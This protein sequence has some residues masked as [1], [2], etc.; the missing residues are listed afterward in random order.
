MNSS[1]TIITNDGTVIMPADTLEKSN[2]LYNVFNTNV[3]LIDLTKSIKVEEAYDTN[4]EYDINCDDLEYIKEFYDEEL[5]HLD[6]ETPDI[7]YFLHQWKINFF[8]DIPHKKLLN[9]HLTTNFLEFNMD[10][11]LC[12][13]LLKKFIKKKPKHTSLH[14]AIK[15]LHHANVR[16]INKYYSKQRKFKTI[17]EFNTYFDIKDIKS[18][19]VTTSTIS[20]PKI[21]TTDK[22]KS[23]V[24][25][26]VTFYQAKTII[27]NTTPNY[28]YGSGSSAGE[29]SSTAKSSSSSSST[30][31]SNLGSTSYS[32]T[33][34]DDEYHYPKTYDQ[35][36]KNSSSTSTGYSKID[37]YYH[38]KTYN[39]TEKN[40]NKSSS[41]PTYY[42]QNKSQVSNYNPSSTYLNATKNMPV[43]SS[44]KPMTVI[45]NYI[46][47]PST[48]LDYFDPNDSGID[49]EFSFLDGQYR[50][51]R[52]KLLD[53]EDDILSY[54]KENYN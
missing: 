54:V 26:G 1:F 42:L 23:T 51:Q 5:L 53:K 33:Y 4:I 49:D 9:L 29:Y 32:K 48:D 12:I 41:L 46:R 44:S 16:I 25:N 47:A 11:D 17:N 21:T 22:P 35:I 40:M 2:F 8:N 13:Y 43:S 20:Y 36:T 28:P 18:N 34:R 15:Y 10:N 45:P 24:I 50:E 30:A 52:H 19:T 37:E 7:K 3:E 14:N 31:K 39:E 27:D 38:P 6:D